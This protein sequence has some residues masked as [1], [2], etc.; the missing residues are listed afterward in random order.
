MSEVVDAQFH[1]G[2]ADEHWTWL[3]S[4]G[5]RNTIERIDAAQI[6]PFKVALTQRLE[7]HRD[8]QGYAFDRPVRFTI[9]RRAA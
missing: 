7:E 4:N 5:H 3:M 8:E 1:F 2:S 9:A 6:E